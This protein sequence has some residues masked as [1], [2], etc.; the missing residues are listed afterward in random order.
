[1]SAPYWRDSKVRTLPFRLVPGIIGS[2]LSGSRTTGL[3]TAPM[4]EKPSPAPIC[5]PVRTV[6]VPVISILA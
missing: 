4:A 6:S 1:M 5:R 3:S 2:L